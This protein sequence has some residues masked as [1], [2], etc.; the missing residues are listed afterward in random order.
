MAYPVNRKIALTYFKSG[1]RATTVA[2]L[3]VLLGISIFIFMNTMSKGFDR[4]SSE[5]F[6]KSTPHIRVYQ[7]D[8]ISQPIQQSSDILPIIANPQILPNKKA[9]ANPYEVLNLLR[10]DSR[11]KLAFPQV[12]SPVFY[13]IGQ[14]Q[15]QGTAIG[16]PPAEG[17]EMYQIQSF[18]VQGNV[19][20]LETNSMGIFIGAGIAEKLNVDTGK[21]IAVTSSKGVSLN[22]TVVGIFQTNNAREDNTKSYVSLSTAQQ[23]LQEGPSFITD[24]NVTVSDPE[25]APEIAPELTAKIGYKAEDW[26]SANKAY[27]AAAKMRSIVITFISFTLLIVSIFGIYNILNMT[28]SQKIN[29]IAILKAMGF[30]GRDVIQIFVLQAITIGTIGVALGLVLALVLISLLQHVYIGGDI[31][32]FPVR[33]EWTVFLKGTCI[34]LFITFL[35]GY[36]PARKAAKVDPVT[37]F[38]K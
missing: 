3:G 5:A 1:R 4:S 2:I 19:L 20:D 7:E 37:I 31:G 33:F 35:A 8:V 32:Y 24:I 25:D 9:I 34:G 21:S 16:F 29:E 10:S 30:N 17:N 22:L 14:S 28:V 26:K 27:M 11:V 38:R 23:F 15:L 6:F 36:V 18:T 12:N 13:N